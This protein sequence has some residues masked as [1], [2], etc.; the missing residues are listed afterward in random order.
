[1]MS[2]GLRLTKAARYVKG[3]SQS[4]SKEVKRSGA[5]PSKSKKV[6]SLS[7]VKSKV[8]Q[9]VSQKVW[10]RVDQARVRQSKE[11]NALEFHRNA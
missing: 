9:K 6:K 11:V 7:K 5:S 10:R 2:K 3:V 8:S 4:K 1:M